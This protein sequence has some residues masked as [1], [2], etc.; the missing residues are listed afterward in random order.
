MVN[1][2]FSID[3]WREK[4]FEPNVRRLADMSPTSKI[5]EESFA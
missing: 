3:L 4:G 2:I 5:K 1:L